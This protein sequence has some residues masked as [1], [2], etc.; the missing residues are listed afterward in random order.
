[1][2]NELFSKAKEPSKII[3]YSLLI[4]NYL[5]RV[6]TKPSAS[7][8]GMKTP[9]YTTHSLAGLNTPHL[10][11]G[12]ISDAQPISQRHAH[13]ILM[14]PM[15]K[16]IQSALAEIR[17]KR[18]HYAIHRSLPQHI[19]KHWFPD[20]TLN[21]RIEHLPASGHIQI[22]HT[23]HPVHITI[24]THILHHMTLMHTSTLQHMALDISAIPYII[25]KLLPLETQHSLHLTTHLIK[26]ATHNPKN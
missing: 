19:I 21:K 11:L 22:K 2:N 16:Q 25:Q 18:Q 8:P 26:T 17:R 7:N 3:H 13:K 14:N 5:K 4:I 6:H 1:M 12:R 23:R 10:S 9:T 15:L 20:L 24:L